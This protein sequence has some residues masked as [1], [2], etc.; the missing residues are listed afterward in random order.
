MVR[1]SKCPTK[2]FGNGYTRKKYAHDEET[3][4]CY[5]NGK[6]GHM[7]SKCRCLPKIGSSNAFI[8]NKKGPKK[9]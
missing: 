7:T 6:V 2:K 3:I 5:F 1:Y 9:I 8:T 4:V